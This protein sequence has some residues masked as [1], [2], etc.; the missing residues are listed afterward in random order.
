MHGPPP[1]GALPK[2]A[3]L[4]P[5]AAAWQYA[6]VGAAAAGGLR[7]GGGS[8]EPMT[9]DE[10][11]DYYVQELCGGV[12]PL[13]VVMQELQHQQHQLD[14][15]APDEEQGG[16]LLPKQQQPPLP[17]QQQDQ[18]RER[19]VGQ[20][21]PQ[22]QDPNATSRASD[23]GGCEV[24]WPP[25]GLPLG[26]QLGGAGGS[27]T[28]SGN[29]AHGQ[30]G[31]AFDSPRD[32][33]Q[34]Q[35]RRQRPRQEVTA[36]SAARQR[37]QQCEE[38]DERQ[39]G[40]GAGVARAGGLCPAR[41]G[42]RCEALLQHGD[43][44]PPSGLDALLNPPAGREEQWP[45]MH[46]EDVCGQGRQDGGAA[47]APAPSPAG[48]PAAAANDGAGA[49]PAVAG[50]G[51]HPSLPPPPLAA[52]N[53][54]T[55]FDARSMF[56]AAGNPPP[57]KAAWPNG[58]GDSAGVGADV[59]ADVVVMVV[60]RRCCDE[61]GHHPQQEQLQQLQAALL[62]AQHQHQHHQHYPHSEVSTAALAPDNLR[63]ELAGAPLLELEPRPSCAHCCVA[64]DVHA[65]VEQAVWGELFASQ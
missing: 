47:G 42:P 19:D 29:G 48:T 17:K 7:G 43:T 1:S 9:D 56:G 6:N 4:T 53:R 23:G 64:A 16:P 63:D 12:D 24:A 3:P 33:Q 59:D 44:L 34:Q 49:A 27:N 32:L 55:D 11:D 58:D 31:L 38:G 28:G 50:G 52:V 30:D 36:D 2:E 25:L 46:G 18:E 13:A 5:P 54:G 51:T 22:Q 20:R 45:R 62:K 37:L 39:G 15:H 8:N 35:Q 65:L 40:G 61:H 41:V 14:A 60:V 10:L 57:G 26:S 21:Q